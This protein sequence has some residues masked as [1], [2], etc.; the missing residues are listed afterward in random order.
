MKLILAS[1][2]PRRAKL[3][4]EAG[5]EFE[6]MNPP[7]DDTQ[8]ELPGM[9]PEDAAKILAWRKA[10]SASEHLEDD[11]VLGADT[12]LSVD[13]RIVG[14]P[15][16]A[17]EAR[18]M[19]REL[20]GRSHEVITGVCL[21]DVETGHQEMFTDTAAVQIGELDEATFEAYLTNEAWR[22]K[23]GGYNLAE[24]REAWPIQVD[25]DADTV[26]G[27]PMQKLTPMLREYLSA[28]S[29]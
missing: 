23:A 14:K 19:L 10:I 3:L 8:A 16:D 13:G 12:L 5:F 21:L 22:G 1:A 6:Q 24:L 29:D 17:D 7:F 9:S 27:L 26:I 18:A 15:A 11:L 20:I 2:S 25:G 28:L 4:R